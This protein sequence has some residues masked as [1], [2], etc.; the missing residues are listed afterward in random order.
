MSAQQYIS[1]RRLPTHLYRGLRLG[2][3]REVLKSRSF[4]GAAVQAPQA[5]RTCSPGAADYHSVTCDILEAAFAIP[6]PGSYAALTSRQ[7]QALCT[8]L[9]SVPNPEG[10]LG[11]ASFYSVCPNP[12][13]PDPRSQCLI[14][15]FWTFSAMCCVCFSRPRLVFKSLKRTCAHHV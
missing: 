11:L 8:L 4:P 14:I 3:R 5:C 12:E 15:V 1:L 9:C 6:R 10:C 13:I 7:S 2:L